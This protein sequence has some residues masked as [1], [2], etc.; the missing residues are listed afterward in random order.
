MARSIV[1]TINRYTDVGAVQRLLKKYQATVVHDLRQKQP[2]SITLRRY[3]GTYIAH[4]RTLCDAYN[5]AAR[6]MNRGKK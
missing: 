4:G 5:K 3:D 2:V 1:Y 6:A